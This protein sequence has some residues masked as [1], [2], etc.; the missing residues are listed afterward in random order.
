MANA[1]S[2]MSHGYLYREN[3]FAGSYGGLKLAR[4]N[5]NDAGETG[6]KG[7]GRRYINPRAGRTPIASGLMI[8]NP[9]YYFARS[10][11]D[12]MHWR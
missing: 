3:L 7:R 8:V 4:T 2:Q 1:Q 10:R 12:R 6:I 9:K 11:N 5:E